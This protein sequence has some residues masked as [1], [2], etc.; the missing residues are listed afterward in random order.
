MKLY[1][2]NQLKDLYGENDPQVKLVKRHID[3]LNPNNDPDADAS[4]KTLEA[5]ERVE[6]KAND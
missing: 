3:R 1:S 2:Y 6:T 5:F 4:N